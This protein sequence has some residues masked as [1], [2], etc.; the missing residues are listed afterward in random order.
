MPND[1]A[2]TLFQI[3]SDPSSA[4]AGVKAF[5]ANFSQSLA[6][7]GLNL[8]EWAAGAQASFK[9]AT[10]GMES[11]T[12]DSTKQFSSLGT[13]LAQH[14]TAVSEWSKSV[15]GSFRDATGSAGTLESG[16]LQSFLSFDSALARN[17]GNA[18]LWQKSIGEAFSQAA[19]KTIAAIASES[20]VRAIY[21]TALGFLL[22][23]EMDFSGAAQAFE[24]A[25]EFAAVGG[26]AALAAHALAGSSAASPS[27]SAGRK[28]SSSSSR[29][30]KSPA[31]AKP[32]QTVQVIFQGPVYG[33]QAGIDELTRKISEAVVERDVNLTA[34]TVVRQPATRA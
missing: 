33:G 2:Q 34:Y 12:N 21:A 22:L 3:A 26:V 18:R 5:Q 32:G 29:S 10:G 8:S 16:L 7:M 24:S 15:S 4:E 23:A 30:S 31:N 11:F 17:I 6:A 13:L 14:R 28:S 27:G 25:A 9:S 1:P 20:I 19:E